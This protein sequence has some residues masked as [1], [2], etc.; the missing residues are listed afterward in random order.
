LH[1][2]RHC[3]GLL[4]ISQRILRKGHDDS[5]SGSQFQAI[6]MSVEYHDIDGIFQLSYLV[7]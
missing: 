1:G 5:A 3:H 4:P 6:L 2:S 7:T